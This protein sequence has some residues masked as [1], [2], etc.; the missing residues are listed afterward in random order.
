MTLCRVLYVCH[1]IAINCLCSHHGCAVS[2]RELQGV[3]CD[4]ISWVDAIGLT[5]GLAIAGGKS[6]LA[7]QAQGA[8]RRSARRQAHCSFPARAAAGRGGHAPL[9]SQQLPRKVL[10]KAAR[11]PCSPKSAQQKCGTGL[12][13]SK[14]ASAGAQWQQICEQVQ[15]PVRAAH[16]QHS[17]NG[18][19]GGLQHANPQT[20]AKQLGQRLLGRQRD[21]RQLLGRARGPRASVRLSAAEQLSD[22]VMPKVRVSLDAQQLSAAPGRAV[23]WARPRRKAAEGVQ[24]MLDHVRRPWKTLQAEA[25]ER[26]LITGDARRWPRKRSRWGRPAEGNV[27]AQPGAAAAGASSLGGRRRF[28]AHANNRAASHSRWAATAE[29]CPSDL[30]LAA[31]EAGSFSNAHTRQQQQTSPAAT[32]DYTAGLPSAG[33]LATAALSLQQHRGVQHFLHLT[34]SHQIA[35]ASTLKGPLHSSPV[36]QGTSPGKQIRQRAQQLA[37]SQTPMGTA[38]KL[39]GGG[40]KRK[41]LGPSQDRRSEGGIQGLQLSSNAELDQNEVCRLI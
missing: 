16:R 40:Y 39:P 35:D 8:G 1:A 14:R 38:S 29:Q 28:Q 23:S 34:A 13:K 20:G 36:A 6:A 31:Q 22:A 32:A 26:P 2:A 11:L 3:S 4:D 33:S 27:P 19:A 9:R 41:Q 30:W 25:Q 10:A 15:D 7:K 21:D 24:R 12:R 5:N 18:E 37:S 17:A